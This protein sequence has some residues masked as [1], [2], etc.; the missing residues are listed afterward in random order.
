MEHLSAAF[1]MPRPDTLGLKLPKLHYLKNLKAAFEDRSLPH[2]CLHVPTSLSVDSV[3]SIDGVNTKL[4]PG[5]LAIT[6]Q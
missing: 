6:A 3:D 5:L 2:C 4:F 1:L